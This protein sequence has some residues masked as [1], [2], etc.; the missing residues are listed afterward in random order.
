MQDRHILVTGSSSGIGQAICQRLLENDAH[1]VGIARN[2]EKFRPK[3]SNYTRYNVN[4]SD[5]KTLPDTL[6]KIRAAHPKLNGLISSAGF[7]EFG[8][9]E[10][11]SAEQIHSYISV[12][13][14]SHMI[15]TR[16]FLPQ[17]KRQNTGDIV[18]IGSEAG[19]LGS[20]KGSLYCAAKFGLRGFCQAIRQETSN[21]G[22]RVT[23]IN[24]GAVRTPFFQ[25]LN[26][27]PGDDPSNAIEADDIANIILNV[28]A[29]RSG[30]VIDEINMTPLKKVLKFSV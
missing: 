19:L 14:I 7:G 20:Q 30:T 1:V 28:L 25:K 9:L 8:P 16:A 17:F 21:K 15:V 18:F 24:P 11:F 29:T 4:L 6:S 22:V 12:N 23:L 26:F 3:Q 13:L 27:S 5:L 10:N 2:H